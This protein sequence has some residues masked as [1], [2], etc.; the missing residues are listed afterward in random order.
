MDFKTTLRGIAAAASM[1]ARCLLGGA[2]VVLS[3]AGLLLISP[4]GHLLFGVPLVLLGL[5]FILRSIF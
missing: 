5:V 2:G 3:V 4:F 1:T